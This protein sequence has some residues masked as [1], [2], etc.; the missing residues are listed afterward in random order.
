M[1]ST[2]GPR[3]S[4]VWLVGLA[5][6]VVL[7][8]P[9]LLFTDA[10]AFDGRREGF[11][12][13]FSAGPGLLHQFGAGAQ[14]GLQTELR[15][16]KARSDRTSIFYSGRQ[17]WHFDDDVFYTEAY[18][19]VG[20]ARYQRPESPSTF[21]GGGGGLALIGGVAGEVAVLSAGPAAYVSAGYEVAP[22]LH[23]EFAAIGSYLPSAKA[24]LI[25]LQIT[26][27]GIAY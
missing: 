21:Y 24:G 5:G 4:G 2:L 11:I 6:L 19:M 25:N 10:R 9:G 27:L 23:I 16:G 17:F 8:S 26:L 13:G 3:I 22:H 20:V 18:P 12:L 15:I 1:K 7:G 14:T